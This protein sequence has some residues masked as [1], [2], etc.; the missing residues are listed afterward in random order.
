MKKC[1][2]VVSVMLFL[3]GCQNSS[4]VREV[5]GA[6]NFVSLEGA[7]LVLKQPLS[8]GPAK[9]RKYGRKISWADLLIWQGDPT[10]D[11]MLIL[12]QDNLRLIMKDG[13]LYKNLTVAPTDESYRGNLRPSGHSFDLPAPSGHSWG[14]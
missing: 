8:I 10:Q 12:E 2:L 5:T 14:M 1:L 6:N 7:R 4:T 3:A 9:A 13:K 11:I